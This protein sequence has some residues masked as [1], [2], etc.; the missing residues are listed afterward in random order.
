MFSNA[1]NPAPTANPQIAAS[2]R[3]PKRRVS[4]RAMTID[5]LSSSSTTGAM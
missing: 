4:S 5:P 2:T 3:K 1:A